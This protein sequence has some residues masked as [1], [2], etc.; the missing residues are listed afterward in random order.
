MTRAVPPGVA[1]RRQRPAVF[2]DKDGT[3]VENVPY[4]VDPA[5]LRFTPGAL[6]GLALLALGGFEL[7]MVSNQPGLA[8]GRFSSGAFERL[9]R[10]LVQRVFDEA[11]VVLSGVYACP[12]APDAAGRPVCACRKPMPG[13]LHEAALD[14][15]LDLG[16]SWMVGD[17]LDDVEAG[18]RAGCRSVLLDVGNETVWE[19]GPLREPDVVAGDLLGAARV[20]VA[21]RLVGE[22]EGRCGG[23]SPRP[24]PQRG[25]GGIP[26]RRDGEGRC[27]GPSPQP[28]PQ[29]GE[30]GIPDRRDGEGRCGGPSP[31]PSPQRG[32]GGIPDRELLA[33]LPLP[34]GEGRGE[35]Q[36]KHTSTPELTAAQGSPP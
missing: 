31:R 4:N 13:L 35:G 32:E 28:S 19:T 1:L 7:V 3:L 23:P 9:R 15:G 18:R 5:R 30:G 14:H 29:R 24:F 34:L 26:G 36:P 6:E 27:G 8:M 11:G 2:I 10:A 33:L 16:R 20:I 25:E 12:H 22:G 17:I 21:D